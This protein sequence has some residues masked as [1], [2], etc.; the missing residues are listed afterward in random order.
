MSQE[1]RIQAL[2]A[3]HHALEEALDEKNHQ[4]QADDLEIVALKKEK[5]RIKD[6]IA[7]LAR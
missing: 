7:Q 5:L 6:Q 1:D 2:Q 3:K 4:P